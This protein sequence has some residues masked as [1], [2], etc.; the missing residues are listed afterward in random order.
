LTTLIG[1][2]KKITII[3]GWRRYGSEKNCMRLILGYPKPSIII[4]RQGR[5]GDLFEMVK[6]PGIVE[7]LQQYGIFDISL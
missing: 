6:V 2:Q 7:L 1:E 5:S 3:S 4:F